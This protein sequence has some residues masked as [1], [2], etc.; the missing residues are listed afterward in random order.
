M[1]D[2]DYDVFL[3]ISLD[4]LAEVLKII[5][6]ALKMKYFVYFY[7]VSSIGHIITFPAGFIYRNECILQKDLRVP[8][9]KCQSF[10]MQSAIHLNFPNAVQ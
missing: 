8:L 7:S 5:S 1:S 4:T 2:T 9:Q 3:N 10:N 6:T